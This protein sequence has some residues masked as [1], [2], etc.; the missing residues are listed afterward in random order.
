MSGR[1]QKT[2]RLY[3]AITFFFQIFLR[4]NGRKWRLQMVGMRL[5]CVTIV[6][7]ILYIWF[8]LQMVLRISIRQ[9]YGKTAFFMHS[10]PACQP[11]PFNHAQFNLN[12]KQTFVHTHTFHKAILS[13]R[14]SSNRLIL[15]ICIVPTNQ[16]CWNIL[17]IFVF[18]LP[19][20]RS[21]DSIHFI[22]IHTLSVYSLVVI[23]VDYE[24]IL[25]MFFF[26][27]IFFLN[28]YYRSMHAAQK[29]L[30][31][32]VNWIINRQPPGLAIHISMLLIIQPILKQKSIACLNV[33]AKNWASIRAIVCYEHHVNS[34]F[35]V[36][37][38]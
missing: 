8:Q 29:V 5:N 9:R 7:I 31:W 20:F 26:F 30:N 10:L 35:W 22:A 34:N 28:F 18:I 27:S 14:C 23:V 21:F 11:T 17:N 16:L 6:I 32:P 24:I 19:L 37:I 12:A 25:K 38:F 3:F 36:R 2:E 13:I 15:H 4:K 1:P 33:C